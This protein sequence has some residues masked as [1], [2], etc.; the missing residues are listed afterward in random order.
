MNTPAT[1]GGLRGLDGATVRA[2]GLALAPLDG[3]AMA[4]VGIL[5][6]AMAKDGVI[7][8]FPS[9]AFTADELRAFCAAAADEAN[10]D[11]VRAL[12]AREFR[13]L[14][15]EYGAGEA[16]VELAR[17]VTAGVVQGFLA[18]DRWYYG[19]K[20][21]PDPPPGAEKGAPREAPSP[22]DWRRV[23]EVLRA[24][25]MRSLGVSVESLQRL[26]REYVAKRAVE[27]KWANEEDRERLGLQLFQWCITSGVAWRPM[28]GAAALE[29]E[30]DSA[31]PEVRHAW[32]LDNAPRLGAARALTGPLKTQ[33]HAD[34]P[35]ALARL[36][37]AVAGE[38]EREDFRKAVGWP[39]PLHH[40]E[41]E[42]EEM[43]APLA[44]LLVYLRARFCPREDSPASAWLKTLER[45][46]REGLAEWRTQGCLEG[47]PP[48]ESPWQKLT[49]SLAASLVA[50]VLWFDRVAAELERIPK[51]LARIPTPLVV[52]EGALAPMFGRSFPRGTKV[53]PQPNGDGR[54]KNVV[55]SRRAAQLDLLMPSRVSLSNPS[56][57][58]VLDML[59]KLLTN[60]EWR[61]FVAVLFAVAEDYEAGEVV[62]PGGFLYTPGRFGRLLGLR[63]RES[64]RKL[65][66]CLDTLM[67][68][69]F[70]ATV[71]R[72]GKDRSL[73]VEALV[74][75]GKSTLT[76]ESQ[77][78]K[79]GRGRPRARLYRLQDE[80]LALLRDGGAWIPV[81]MNMLRAPD[82]VDQRT[83]DDAFKLETVMAAYAR[84]EA[85]KAKH[86]D[87]LPWTRKAAT[88][89][90]ATGVVAESARPHVRTQ[91]LRE[92]LKA[93]CS[94]GR[95][96]AEYDEQTQRVRYDLPELRPTLCKIQRRNPPKTLGSK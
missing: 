24:A 33:S 91:R 84:Q 47:V 68:V 19:A 77:P 55:I 63:D 23:L 20:A 35:E 51:P 73:K 54:L 86:G 89:L 74:L 4:A 88:L 92:L 81:T 22:E 41:E 65:D 76:E 48:P 95:V 90:E 3:D 5:A 87:P 37:E 34:T 70:S 67:R 15:P 6:F 11:L 31:W 12:A 30:F 17:E 60:R 25:L 14:A 26:A 83:W 52:G 49:P 46:G 85:A 1:D 56:N 8:S 50:Q 40:A 39:W 38:L 32:E 18:L 42:A 16:Q 61:F 9:D 27:W 28:E 80:L 82:Q 45:Q 29:R 36:R 58:Q 53:V 7:A 69:G 78:A 21:P 93:V 79:R 94:T 44:R 10:H 57:E 72:G 62:V 2:E 13:T 75:D 59:A 66:D 96:V 71:K 43:A 64:T